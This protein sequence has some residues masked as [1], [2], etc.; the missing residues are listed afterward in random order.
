MRHMP[1]NRW[2]FLALFAVVVLATSGIAR[3]DEVTPTNPCW[4]DDIS[5]GALIWKGDLAPTPC[6]AYA[7]LINPCS[8]C[9]CGA[10]SYATIWGVWYCGSGGDACYCCH[11]VVQC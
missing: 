10:C 8:F 4:I 5:N 3:A 1:L 9:D 6:T 2:I 11:C 7:N